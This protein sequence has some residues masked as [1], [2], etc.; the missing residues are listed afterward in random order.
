MILDVNR[1]HSG[2]WPGCWSFNVRV[3]GRMTAR[4]IYIEH[5]IIG[6]S[7][8][9]EMEI[10]DDLI[11]MKPW[12]KPQQRKKFPS[13]ASGK[14]GMYLVSRYRWPCHLLP[15]KSVGRAKGVNPC[16]WGVDEII[17][18]TYNSSDCRRCLIAQIMV[19]CWRASGHVIQRSVIACF[20]KVSER[21]RN[22]KDPL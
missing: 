21:R 19:E 8:V 15:R 1:T 14:Y 20:G 4:Y 3:Y 13:S 18:A 9:R 11:A 6:C 7:T 2:S 17:R 5:V 22:C 10:V 12:Q 16:D